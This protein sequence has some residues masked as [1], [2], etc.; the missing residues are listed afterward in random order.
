MKE[1][2]ISGAARTPIGGLGGSLAK[3]SAVELGEISSKESLVRSGVDASQVG[4]VIFGNVLQ[5]GLGQNPARQISIGCGVPEISPAFTV[6]QVC[7]SGLKAID[8]AYRSIMLG[9]AEVVLAGGIESMSRSPYILP[10]L[11]GGARFGKNSVLDTAE[12]DGLTDAFGKY[13]M[14]ITAENIAEKYDI[15]REEQDA[16][17]AES[18][19]RCGASIEKGM[20]KDEIV[21][22]R[23]KQRKNK[24]VVDQDEH[25]RPDTTTEKLAKLRPAFKKEGTVTAGNASGINDGAASLVV[26]EG[27]RFADKSKC[28]R[29][30]DIT[31]V[32][33]APELMGLGPVEAV[34]K[35]LHQQKL[36]V[37]DIDIWELN[38]A[39]AVQALSV[40]DQLKLDSSRVNVNGGAIALGHPIGASGTRIV[41]TL[42]HLMKKQ[43]AN[44]GVASLCVGGGMGLAI[45]LEN[46]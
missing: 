11:R 18:Q 29:I 10:A 12:S 17:A 31:C 34:R 24:I 15:S 16:F 32:G 19:H 30:R 26:A 9:E 2:L 14:G 13:H 33:C 8:L 7:G 41:V 35:L 3:L 37:N 38:E 20:F 36:T 25:P 43:N 1:V 4:E 39:F 45:L 6:N 21:S 28:V 22:V 40:L 23:I 5:A 44:L 27:T 46:M 42:I